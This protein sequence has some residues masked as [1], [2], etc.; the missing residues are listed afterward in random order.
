M[1]E[2]GKGGL[3]SIVDKGTVYDTGLIDF[4]LGTARRADIPVQLKRYSAGSNDAAHI[5]KTADGA[6]VL[7]LSAP[8]RY[9]HS[10]SC[11]ADV[12]D[13][14]AICALLREMLIHFP[15]DGGSLA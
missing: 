14:A 5:H 9:I 7:A 13:Y 8:A 15:A 12:R 11:V 6:R 1:G 2:L 4:A 10:G 3:V